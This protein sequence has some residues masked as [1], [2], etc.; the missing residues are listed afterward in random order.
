MSGILAQAPVVGRVSYQQAA[1]LS[2]DTQA[3]QSQ[4]FDD[5]LNAA[6]EV[7]LTQINNSPK[8]LSH[9]EIYRDTKSLLSQTKE[10]LS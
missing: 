7:H 3:T 9:V 1:R 8:A 5:R 2:A 6:T 10:A 4:A